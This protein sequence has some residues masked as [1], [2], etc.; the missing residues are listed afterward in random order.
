MIPATLTVSAML[1][2][3]QTVVTSFGGLIV[4]A[5]GLAIGIWAVRFTIKRVKRLG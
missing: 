1:T 4:L 3:A 5:A 2:S